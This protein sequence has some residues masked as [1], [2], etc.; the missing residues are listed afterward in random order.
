MPSLSGFPAAKQEDPNSCWACASREISNYYKSLGKGGKNEMYSSDKELAAAWSKI[1]G[2]PGNADISIQ[3][4]AS[5]ALGDLGYTNSADSAPVP[6]VGEITDAINDK[7]PLLAI[8]GS[9]DPKGKRK[10][11]YQQGHWVVITGISDKGDLIEVFDP[12]SGKIETVAYSSQVY[13]SG[14]FWQN[15][16]YVDGQ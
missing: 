8:V 2:K 12:D 13:K 16:S 11:G 5:A 6:T 3:Q 9:T 1:T 7:K 15:T 14:M 10:L 4:S